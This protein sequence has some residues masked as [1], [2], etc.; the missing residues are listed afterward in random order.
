[1][2]KT[3]R[4]LKFNA[5]FLAYGI[6]NVNLKAAPRLMKFHLNFSS[7]YVLFEAKKTA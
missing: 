2:I 7:R 3:D 1:M 4:I 5:V 6:C